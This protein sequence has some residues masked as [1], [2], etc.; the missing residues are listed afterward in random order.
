MKVYIAGPDVFKPD[1][2]VIGTLYKHILNK[3][4]HEGLYPLDNQCSTAA[5][6]VYGNYNLIDECD[7]VIA[8]CNPFR[9][10]E[11][12]SGTCCEIGYAIAQGKKIICYLEDIRSQVAKIGNFD[13]NGYSVEDF[14]YPI[15]I[16]MAA[17]KN[18]E[19]IKGD[20]ETAVM[21]II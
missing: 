10:L 19:I 7:I 5:E 3:Y 12:D 14:H 20:F 18:V 16:M 6:I 8:N 1:A 2:V 9:G 15:N 13:N 17:H 21:S 4:G 11:P